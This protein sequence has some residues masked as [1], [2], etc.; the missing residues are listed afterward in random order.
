MSL[1]VE[2]EVLLEIHLCVS[3]SFILFYHLDNNF[4]VGLV[5]IHSFMENKDDKHSCF[6]TIPYFVTVVNLLWR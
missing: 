6:S 5:D 3:T 1:F 4:I 2:T